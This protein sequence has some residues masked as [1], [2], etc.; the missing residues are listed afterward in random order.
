MNFKTL[1]LLLF[2]SSCSYYN[3][4]PD[5]V[6]YTKEE[7]KE[8]LNYLEKNDNKLVEKFLIDYYNLRKDIKICKK[9][10]SST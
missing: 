2:L 6:I 5:L 7:Q 10:S 1:F 4:C 9:V 3:V 8:L